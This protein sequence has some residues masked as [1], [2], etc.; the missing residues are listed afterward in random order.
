MG[1]SVVFVI[2]AGTTGCRAIIFS[3]RGEKLA[4]AYKEFP[5]S[6]PQ[7]DWVEQNAEDW[8]KAICECCKSV[9]NELD[10]SSEI[11]AL[12]VT[13]QRETVVPVDEKGDVLGPAVVWQ[14]RRSTVECIWLAE[15][16]G[17]ERI[18]NITGLTIDPYF[19]APKLLWLSAH[20]PESFQKTH[21]F[22]LVHDYIIYRLTGKFVTDHSNASR[23]LLFDLKERC[24]SEELLTEM[25]INEDKLPGIQA[26]GTF[27]DELST[28]ASTETGLP[29]GL[30]V[31]TGGGDQQCA[32]LGSGVTAVGRVS[33]TTGTGTFMV[34]FAE[35]PLFDPWRR[36]LCSA[37]VVP[38][39]YIIEASM[40]TTGAAYRWLR[41][42]FAKDLLDTGKDPYEILNNEAEASEPG[43]RGL[44]FIPHLAG[45]GAPHWDPAAVGVIYGLSL[46]HNRGD[47]VRAM[48]EG[49]A[50]EL[51]KNQDILKAM[52]L[53]ISVLSISGGGA[54]S[55]LWN[56]IIADMCQVPVL[57]SSEDAT[58]LGAAVLV[59]AGAK[60]YKNLDE[61]VDV[62]VKRGGE[63]NPDSDITNTYQDVYERSLKLYESITSS[64]EKNLP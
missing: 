9:M 20:D 13:N 25:R 53:D 5:S 52:G 27:V 29:D 11:S 46:G 14:D 28:A 18:Y 44:T 23:T 16:I 57:K 64:G 37:H 61:A 55:E 21:K 17:V 45:A 42:N 59:A 6:Y 40:F 30:H 58:A 36:V 31:Y 38:G 35:K 10:N 62:M 1:D 32:A 43:A 26:P 33:A 63:M 50:V 34:A 3:K 12:T 49:V 60:I 41:D 7:P 22:L 2:D 19:T 8:W 56:Q 54:R 48:M 47:I 4:S 24:W 15:K 39:R 51:R